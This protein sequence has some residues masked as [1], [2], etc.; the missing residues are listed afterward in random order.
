MSAEIKLH[1]QHRRIKS[2]EITADRTSDNMSALDLL[3]TGGLVET[4]SKYN[5]QIDDC[6]IQFLKG[7]DN[8]E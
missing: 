4:I 5:S 3:Q 8:D 7:G 1:M 2:I 6:V